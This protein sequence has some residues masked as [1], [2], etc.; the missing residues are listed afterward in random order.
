MFT[1][2]RGHCSFTAEG[3]NPSQLDQMTRTAKILLQ[4]VNAYEALLFS[5]VLTALSVFH[6]PSYYHFWL[7]EHLFSSRPLFPF[8][9]SCISGQVYLL[10]SF[11]L[12]PAA[13]LLAAT[14]N[15]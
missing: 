14:H 1:D 7:S 9:P 4:L 10:L 11:S 12:R 3:T 6:G 13:L 2:T 15:L 8:L 5:P